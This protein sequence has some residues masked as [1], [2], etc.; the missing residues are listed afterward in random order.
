M[1]QGSVTPTSKS[2][3]KVIEHIAPAPSHQDTD[4]QEVDWPDAILVE[5]LSQTDQQND[6][7]ITIQLTRC[8]S[9]PVE[10]PQLEENSEEEQYQD[11]D[12]Y[13][14][15]HNTFETSKHICRDYQSRLLTLDEEKYYKKV[16]RAFYTYGTPAAHD[17]R[18]GNQAPGPCRTT[19]ELMQIFGKG[20]GQVHREE[21]HGYRPFG[22]R[23][24]LLQSGIQ[25][26][27]KKTQQM[28]QRYANAQ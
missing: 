16:D 2:P 27:I 20:E 7:R 4:T 12:T 17:Y 18:L 1:T 5:I 22:T 9:E 14:M 25:W 10:I 28:R 19:Q 6:Q 24:R 11:L 8:N 15:H 13:L 21:L 26:K 23:T 3:E